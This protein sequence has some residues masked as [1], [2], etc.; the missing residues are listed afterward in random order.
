[1]RLDLCIKDKLNISRQKAREII[2]QGLVTVDKKNI[3]KPSYNVNEDADIN[4]GSTESILKYVG[5][6][7]YKLEKAIDFFNINLTGYVC[8]DIGASTGGFTD[9]M[10]Q[11]G[12]G[13]DQLSPMLLNDNR[14][15]SWENTDI[16]NVTKEM[17]DNGVDFVGCDVSF[18][19]L[20]KIFPEIKKLLKPNSIAVVLIKPQFECGREFLS[21]RQV[22]LDCQLLV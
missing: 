2:E 18:I 16:R 13:T 1:M 15:I 17:V 8:I 14:V 6:G 3:T 10:L 21:R 4:V 7:G 12:V 11:N 9:C 19:S 22:M 20:K 5:R